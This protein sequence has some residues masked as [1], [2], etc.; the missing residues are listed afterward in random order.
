MIVKTVTVVRKEHPA[1]K[2]DINESD[3]KDSDV[4]YQD[5]PK[6]KTRTNKR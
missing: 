1:G 5:T 3:L 4:I 6:P 2:V